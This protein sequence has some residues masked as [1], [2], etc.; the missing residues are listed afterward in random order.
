MLKIS[1]MERTKL[2]YCLPKTKRPERDGCWY[3][4]FIFNITPA[5]SQDQSS[6][7][8]H[9]VDD[10]VF[11]SDIIWV[12]I[13]KNSSSSLL[14]VEQN[15]QIVLRTMERG[16]TSVVVRK[17]GIDQLNCSSILCVKETRIQLF[18]LTIN[19]W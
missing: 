3:A 8:I 10:G 12:F 5:Q 6:L 7:P 9:S 4:S 14:E 2:P 11:H 13:G 1:V 17:F 15:I 19:T 16:T 18:Q